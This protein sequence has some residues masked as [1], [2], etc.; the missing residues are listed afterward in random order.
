MSIDEI[1][2]ICLFLKQYRCVIGYVNVCQVSSCKHN[3]IQSV[4]I[5][6]FPNLFLFERPHLSE[7]EYL[8]LNIAIVEQIL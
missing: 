3:L 2:K 4:N 7:F 1:N 8:I 6:L 5:G